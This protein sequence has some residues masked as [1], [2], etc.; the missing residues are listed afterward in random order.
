M[1]IFV[2][3]HNKNLPPLEFVGNKSNW[4]D[5]RASERVEMKEGEKK[6]IPL[7]V[8]MKLPYG[9]EAWL[10]PRSSTEKKFGIIQ[11][12]SMGIIDN[13]FSGTND[14]WMFPAIARRDT[15]IEE[16]DR[17][18]QFRIMPSMKRDIELIDSE[19]LDDTDRGGFG[20]TGVK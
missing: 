14:I 8:S 19:E 9:Y 10:L 13:S 17:I 7:G 1:K 3:Y 5:L 20:S 15:V 18:C 12:N 11:A 16:G 4:I 2:K 6:L